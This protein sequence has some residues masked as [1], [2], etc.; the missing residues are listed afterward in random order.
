MVGDFNFAVGLLR[1]GDCKGGAEGGRGGGRG[2]QARVRKWWIKG[3]VSRAVL[4]GLKIRPRA[5]YWVHAAF[6]KAH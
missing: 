1:A 4:V 2:A 5:V 6:T 3:V